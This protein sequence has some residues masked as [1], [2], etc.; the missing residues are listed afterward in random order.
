MSAERD[1]LPAFSKASPLGRL[2][3]AHICVF[4]S[5]GNN[6]ADRYKRLA[7]LLG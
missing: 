6:I 1:N 4:C 3:G 2:G 7:F 5:S